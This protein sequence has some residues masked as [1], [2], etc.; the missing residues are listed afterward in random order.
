MRKVLRT[1]SVI[2][3]AGILLV[4]CNKNSPKSVATTWLNDFYHADYD[5]AIPFSTEI[6][7]VQLEQ[8]SQLYTYVNDSMKK[9]LKKIPVTI[10]DVKEKGD[11]AVATYTV[12]DKTKEQNLVLIKQNGKW[13]VAFTK[14]DAFNAK[15]FNSDQPPATDTTGTNNVPVDTAATDTA[16]NRD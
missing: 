1:V 6:T 10:K 9:D 16:K 13:L 12:G 2:L 14:S 8:F 15:D 7:K 3:I 4:S 5:A 11:T